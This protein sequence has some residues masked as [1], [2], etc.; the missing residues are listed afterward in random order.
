MLQ[1]QSPFQQL[2]D[3]NGS[4]LDD[5]YVYIGTA[6]ANPETSPIAIYWD[7][8]GTIPAAQPLRTL[9]GYLVRSG[10]PARVYTAADDFS[11]TVKDRQ[12]RVVFSVLDATSD[13]NLTTA[14]ASSS[15]SS[16]VGF[17]QAG[18]N[19]Q[20]R[21]VQSKLRDVVSVLDFMTDA[22]IAGVAAGTG[23]ASVGIQKALDSDAKVIYFPPGYYRLESP[24]LIKNQASSFG[25]TLYGSK[26]QTYLIPIAGL[27]TA[28]DILKGADGALSLVIKDIRFSAE[29]AYTGWCIRA[30]GT[31]TLIDS[32]IEG[33]WTGSGSLSAGFF[34]GKTVFSSFIN[35]VHELSKVFARCTLASAVSFIN[36]KFFEVYDE[37]FYFDGTSASNGIVIDG[38]NVNAHNRGSFIK[39]INTS[40]LIVSNVDYQAGTTLVDSGQHCKFAEL[41][42]STA[43]F[44][45]CRIISTQVVGYA[46]AYKVNDAFKITG[47]T[48]QI[49]D[50]YVTHCEYGVRH[51]G[52]CEITVADSR[53]NNSTWCASVESGATGT[54]ILRGNHF[55]TI[56]YRPLAIPSANSVNFVIDGNYL[57]NPCRSIATYC[58]YIYTNGYTVM[59]NN[60]TRVTDSQVSYW[61]DVDSAAT[62]ATLI[63]GNTFIGTPTI[64]NFSA[65]DVYKL[66]ANN[67]GLYSL[68]YA[69]SAPTVGTWKQGDR[70]INQAPSVGAAKGWVC[71][72]AGTPGTWVSE[73]NL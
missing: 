39:A 43:N 11:M 69:S 37:M 55:S 6:N 57:L 26:S 31:G 1:I 73:G 34:Y 14:L 16:L 9:N 56:G 42:S 15:G 38:T 2:F 29:G 23:D 54:L 40:N 50:S 71:T 3:T 58:W 8:A 49:S 67:I 20:L 72:V 13:S 61:F 36:N 65:G 46:T 59:K 51:Y 41:D 10:T 64:G 66:G 4:P 21:T 47:S 70:V 62:N 19:A 60:F 53:I 28:I 45:N 17:L 68:Y 22:E 25:K 32:R 35:N 27:E 63:D 33:C 52:S 24:L 48:V 7:D 44:S 5:G 12:G 18:A 30:L